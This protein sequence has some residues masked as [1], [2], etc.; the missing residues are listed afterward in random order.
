MS[1]SRLYAI[2]AASDYEN[3]RRREVRPLQGAEADARSVAELLLSQP[4]AGGELFG[5]TLLLGRLATTKA[6]REAIARGLRATTRKGDTLLV[7]FAGHGRRDPGGLVLYTASGTYPAAR[8]IRDLGTD[9]EPVA[10]ILDCCHAGAVTASKQ[11]AI[12][13]DRR[14]RM[15][16]LHLNQL[17]FIC[18]S[19]AEQSSFERGGRG[20][21]S[22]KL[23]EA[24]RTPIEPPLLALPLDVA[25]WCYALPKDLLDAYELVEDDRD[26]LPQAEGRS[27]AGAAAVRPEQT[28]VT[29][30]APTPPAGGAEQ[31]WQ[32]ETGPTQATEGEQ[33]PVV[34]AP[35]IPN[36]APR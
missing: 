8:L 19:T 32:A 27:Q 21:F 28:Y 2:I 11:A 4:I 24:L 9:R 34:Q 36:A 17:Q 10:V 25:S 33:S 23:V 13:A 29:E 26:I 35:F 1:T 3:D 22:Q 16:K 6:L 5:L 30:G 18:S 7:F 31:N 12:E 15:I 14:D 20:V